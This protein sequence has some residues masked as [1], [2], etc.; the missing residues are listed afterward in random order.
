[1]YTINRTYVKYCPSFEISCFTY[2]NVELNKYYLL[3]S[4]IYLL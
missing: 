4:V 1:M 2:V 3:N